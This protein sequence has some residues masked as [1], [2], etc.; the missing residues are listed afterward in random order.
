MKL[1]T[2][3]RV[4]EVVEAVH[5][6]SSDN[7]RSACHEEVGVLQRCQAHINA[8]NILYSAGRIWWIVHLWVDSEQ[9]AEQY[10]RL[11]KA[12]CTHI[13][14]VSF[15]KNPLLYAVRDIDLSI[16]PYASLL[17]LFHVPATSFYL[18]ISRSILMYNVISVPANYVIIPDA[19]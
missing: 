14:T 7:K 18:I 8:A 19:S 16:V 3:G 5:D 4:A 9:S 1:H 12:S 13:D 11:L 15:L 6:I 10:N 17:V 2:P